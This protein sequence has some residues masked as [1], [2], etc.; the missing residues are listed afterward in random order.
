VKNQLL[1]ATTNQGKLRELQALLRGLDLRLITPKE[2]SVELD[3][4]ETGVTYRENASLKALAYARATGLISLADDSGL[5]VAA[6]EG[7][8]G[9]RSARFSPKASATDADRREY[10]LEN[11]A[12]FPRPWQARFVCMVV[13]ATP[14]E[15]LFF[16]EGVCPGEIIP[17][18][19]GTGGFGYDPIFFLPE[20]HQTMAELDV[21]TKNL[22]SH[23]G[24][25]VTAMHPHLRDLFAPPN[26]K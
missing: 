3:V 26:S 11:L 10:L 25:A 12:K 20:Q 2:L 14:R 1:L 24:R 5:E 9:V 19:R 8:P 7:A 18:E 21:Q 6:L 15:E 17:E 16:T 23:R 4:P 13:V 22:I